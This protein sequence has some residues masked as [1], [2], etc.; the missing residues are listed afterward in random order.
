METLG[1]TLKSTR[2]NVSLTLKDVE[3]ATGISNAYL[4]QLENEKI[5]K[6]SASIL[7][8]LANVYKIDLNVL[9]HA[10]G[11]IEKS[12]ETEAPKLTLLEK[13][14]QFYKDKLSPQEEKEVVDFI[15]FLRYKKTNDTTL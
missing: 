12:D 15:K 10:A 6:P 3:N 7:Y 2:E 5:K 13:E 9:L 4:S 8:K 14:I 11:I 1:K